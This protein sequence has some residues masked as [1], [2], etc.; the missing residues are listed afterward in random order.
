MEI[1]G[2]WISSS[3]Q[4][5]LRACDVVE[6]GGNVM[7]G[8]LSIDVYCVWV[9]TAREHQL[10]TACERVRGGTMQ[11]GAAFFIGRVGVAA[12]ANQHR[13]H[14]IP[15]RGWHNAARHG[16][17]LV[18]CWDRR[19]NEAISSRHRSFRNRHSGP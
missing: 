13:D 12:G 10:E 4:Q 1:A 19:R 17:Y 2:R 3:S 11:R 9:C 6:Q 8:G 18:P 7:Q 15:P 16:Q 5:E 14:V